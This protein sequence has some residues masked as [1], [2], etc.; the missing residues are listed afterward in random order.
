VFFSRVQPRQVARGNWVSR[1]IA[2]IWDAATA[3]EIVVL[4]GHE[5]SITSAAFNPDGSRIVTAS[6]DM[7]A[8]IWDVHLETMSVKGL[9]VEACVRLAGQTKLTR[10]E[11]RLAGYPDEMQEIDVCQ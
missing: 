8:R 6:Y 1:H 11:M 5:G 10:D 4:R 9:L 2:R 3:K 7:S